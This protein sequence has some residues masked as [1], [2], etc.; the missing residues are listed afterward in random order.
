MKNKTNFNSLLEI[1][2]VFSNDKTCR[3]YFEKIRWNNK[4]V[5]PHCNSDEKIYR[6][7][8]GKR[9]KCS[10]C[11]KQFTVTVGTI[12]AS[13]HIPLKKWFWAIFLFSSHKKGISSIQLGKDISVQQRT[14][15]FMLQRIRYAMNS[16]GFLKS[17]TGEVEIDETL[18]GGKE[19]NK[20]K[21]KRIE[22]SQ[23]RSSK[24]KSVVLGMR[25]RDGDVKAFKVKGAGSDQLHP[26]ILRNVQ[27][28]TKIMTDDWT[29]Y[30]GLD[31]IYEHE[32][33]NH[34]SGEY[35]KGDV[36]TNNIENFWSLLKRGVY[37]IYH[38]A[39]PKHLHRYVNEFAF[40]YNSR[41]IAESSRFDLA[42]SQCDGRL[43]YKQLTK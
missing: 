21:H 9:Y 33:V 34:K 11:K 26:A 20:H 12:F 32:T 28:G 10:K 35:V 27:P 14:A 13:S 42:L 16:G 41:N 2:E 37:G 39:S 43:T 3:E 25:Q 23:G 17:L 18:I 15:W 36:H 7:S 19:K 24:G 6:F 22:G 31:K 1:T 29:G 4:L 38:H 5:C 8:D 40:R 30:K